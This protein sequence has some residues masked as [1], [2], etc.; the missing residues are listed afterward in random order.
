VSSFSVGSIY[1]R[2]LARLK[3]VLASRVVWLTTERRNLD[4][5]VSDAHAW[6]AVVGREHYEQTQR[7]YPVRSWFDLRRVL[8]LELAGERDWFAAIGPLEAD[9]R[10]V[11]I[12]RLRPDSPR[13]QLRAAFWLPETLCLGQ[14]AR[15]RGVV[16]VERDGLKYFLASSGASVLAG[17]AI[18]SPEVFA[19]ASGI[20]PSGEPCV[21]GAVDIRREI[22]E[23]L[24]ILS[25]ADWWSFRS[26]AAAAHVRR[27]T[28]PV[29][30]FVCFALVAYLGLVSAYLSGMELLRTRQI[31][32]L[33]PEVTSLLVQQRAV[34]LMATERAA[35]AEVVAE[36][37]S[38]WPIWEV[39]SAIW[40]ANGAIYS[41]SIVDDVITVRCTG[42]VATQVLEA[43]RG[44]KGYD[45][46]QFDSAVRQG[47]VGQEFV[48]SLRRN[49]GGAQRK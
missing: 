1:G 30:V 25:R 43:L 46:V 37:K 22:S 11:T 13:D 45:S 23:A 16:T 20:V 33:G 12:F 49:A 10:Q 4:G 28:Q 2:L 38:I 32:S 29:A 35:L 47:G 6:V 18:R 24:F 39:A 44:L 14:V 5:D 48:V 26:P 9:E 34:D 3:F 15:R 17:G 31:D 36:D 27:F 8:R 40:G 42:P 19:V 7:R 21:L 41:L